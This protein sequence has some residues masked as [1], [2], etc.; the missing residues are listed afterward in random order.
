MTLQFGTIVPAG[1][2]TFCFNSQFIT[3]VFGSETPEEKDSA[4]FCFRKNETC[5]GRDHELSELAYQKKRLVAK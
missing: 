2:K 5:T 4:Y 1:K 3:S